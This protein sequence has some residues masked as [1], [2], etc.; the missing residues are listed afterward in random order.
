MIK[1]VLAHQVGVRHAGCERFG[2]IG[3]HDFV[4]AA[5][6]VPLIDVHQLLTFIGGIKRAS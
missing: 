5:N 1:V 2:E 3:G 6:E 4:G